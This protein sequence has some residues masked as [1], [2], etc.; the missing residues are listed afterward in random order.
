MPRTLRILIFLFLFSPAAAHAQ[1]AG[2][3]KML[4]SLKTELSKAKEDTNKV[5]ILVTLSSMQA[6]YEPREALKYSM[7]AV[8]LAKKLQWEKG[9]AKAYNTLGA[10]YRGLSDYPN[11]LNSYFRSLEI[12]EALGDKKSV[13]RTTANVGS[14]YRENKD[15]PKALEYY[16]KALKVNEAL[17]QKMSMTNN[18]SDMGIVYAEM[19]KRDTALVYFNK[20]LKLSA[21]IDDQE[22]IAIVNSNIGY[23]YVK[24]LKYEDAISNFSKAAAIN[25]AI[26]R[27]IGLAINNTNLGE[28]YYDLAADTGKVKRNLSAAE[29]EADLNKAVTYLN[30]AIPI[31]SRLSA[32]DNLSD[33]YKTLY[34][35]YLLRNDYKN[36]FEAYRQHTMIRDSVFSGD[37]KVKIANLATE[38]AEYEKAQQAKL[39]DLAQNKRRNETILFALVIV[40]LLMF[41]IFVVR[42]RRKSENLLLN[43]LPAEVADELK[44]KGSAGARHFD[45]ITVIFT[46]FVNFTTVAEK[47]HPQALVDELDICFKAFDRIVT[48]YHIEKIKTI[49]DAYMAV[50]GL[51]VPDAQHAVKMVKA[52]MEIA[53]FVEQRKKQVGEM[54]FDIRIGLNSGSVVA[55]IV[56]LKKFVYDIWGDTVNTA[57]R[58]EQNSEPGKINISQSTY[59]LVK[60][61]FVCTCRGEL[62]VKNKGKLKMYFVEK[63]LA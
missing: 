61:Q 18:Y 55:G 2:R 23:M 7:P 36:A 24:A 34:M 60:D 33:A 13:A 58:M 15:Y 57:A 12:N 38:R 63:A 29:K 30:E 62:E 16:E 22:G 56:G 5:N 47:M 8:E 52:A 14:V 31:L 3:E 19:A 48:K 49:G 51:P 11:A 10:G 39:T 21:E 37:K 40:L 1:P 50:A 17:G 26:G 46:D 9:I 20:A 35:V 44:K 4:D 27:E 42:E 28:I 45:S 6:N 25:K 43:I 41:V 32:L 53:A 59:E 54:A